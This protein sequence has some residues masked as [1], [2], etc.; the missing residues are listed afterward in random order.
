MRDPIPTLPAH[1]IAWD[2]ERHKPE[3]ERDENARQAPLHA[4]DYEQ[5]AHDSPREVVER[6]T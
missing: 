5:P 2:I 1:I 4:P 3:H 6:M